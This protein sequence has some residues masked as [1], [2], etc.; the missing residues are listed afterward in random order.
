M[1]T[2]RYAVRTPLV[3][4][5]AQPA[6]CKGSP[7]QALVC[8]AGQVLVSLE[9][10][11][12][13]IDKARLTRLQFH[14]VHDQ[15]KR[16]VIAPC[17]VVPI[18][19]KPISIDQ[20]PGHFPEHGAPYRTNPVRYRYR[21]D[22]CIGVGVDCHVGGVGERSDTHTC[23]GLADDVG[24]NSTHI[25]AGISRLDGQYGSEVIGPSFTH[26]LGVAKAAHVVWTTGEPVRY[27]VAVLVRNHTVVEV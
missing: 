16:K 8:T 20:C 3:C 10:G 26:L 21:T 17:A 15:L 13:A 19:V 11:V 9:D 6:F 24:T 14:A 23:G 22:V 12:T 7:N 4:K 27:T 25:C 5:Y 2:I 1:G 18:W